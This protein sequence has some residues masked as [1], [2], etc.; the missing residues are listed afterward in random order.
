MRRVKVEAGL[1]I[2]LLFFGT[3]MIDAVRRHA[4]ATC[5][6]YV[7]LALLF[8]KSGPRREDALSGRAREV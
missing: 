3:A 7:L 2:F 6:V 5:I 1:V 4:W 8:L